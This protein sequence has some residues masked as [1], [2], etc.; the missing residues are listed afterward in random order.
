MGKDESDYN[1]TVFFELSLVNADKPPIDPEVVAERVEKFLDLAELPDQW[2]VVLTRAP[3]FA[4]KLTYLQDCIPSTTDGKEPKVN[5][6]VGTDTLVRL[7]NPK[8]YGNDETNMMESLRAM[9]GAHFIVGGRLEQ[10][11]DTDRPK[12]VSG[13]EEL[14]LLPQDFVKDMFTIMEESEFRVDISSSEI[15]RKQ[16]ENGPSNNSY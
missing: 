3:L 11:V 14:A 9:N 12:F 1:P 10:N 4:E 2:G 6:V 15:R 7:I 8:Y 5:F 13:Q 16:S